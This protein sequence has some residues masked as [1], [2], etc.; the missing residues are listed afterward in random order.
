MGLAS[1]VSAAALIVAVLFM[2]GAAQSSG[3]ILDTCNQG[4]MGLNGLSFDDCRSI[5]ASIKK[6][7]TSEAKYLSLLIVIARVE[8]TLFL[9]LGVGAIWSLFFLQKGTK[10]VAVVHLMH[11]VW[12][13][14]VCAVHMDEAGLLV[15]YSSPD[16]NTDPNFYVQV[17]IH[18]V[19]GFLA[20]LFWLA[21]LMSL[22]N[23]PTPKEKVQ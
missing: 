1:K 9:G 21:F 15:P 16:P 20:A 22:S 19:T 5:G 18:F 13:T 6:S 10:E 8:A 23:K 3:S 2:I 17:P 11:A 7:G 12:A 14:A 4:G